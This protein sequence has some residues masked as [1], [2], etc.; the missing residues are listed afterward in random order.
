M[1]KIIKKIINNLGYEISK[2]Y[3]NEKKKK[4]VFCTP[5]SILSNK[6]IIDLDALVQLS[7]TIPGM[8]TTE[9]GKML[10]TLCYLQEIKGDVV[11]IGSW[12][13]RSTSFLARAVKESING[14]LFAIDHFQGNIGKEQLYKVKNDDL[15]DL[16]SGFISNMKHLGLVDVINLLEMNSQE[17]SNRIASNSIRFLFIDGD[18]TYNGVLK[19]IELFFPKLVNNAIVVFDDFSDNFPGLIIAVDNIIELKNI[20]N[21]LTF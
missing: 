11:E 4:N 12:Q 16:K 17:A 21:V 6:Q 2:K 10:Y 18:H 8:I 15:S 7:E 5:Y 14:K 13:G 19:D 9:S 3:E 20:I 1:K